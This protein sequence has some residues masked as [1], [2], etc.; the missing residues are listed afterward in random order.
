MPLPE[1]GGGIGMA[2]LFVT[3]TIGTSMFLAA[4]RRTEFS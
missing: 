1:I 2:V 4:G 3:M